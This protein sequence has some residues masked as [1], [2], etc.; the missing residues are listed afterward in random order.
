M[1]PLQSAY[2]SGHSTETALTRVTN[3]ILSSLDSRKSVFLV[4]LDLLAAFDIVDH[5]ILLNR[6][7]ARIGLGGT[8]L[9]WVKSYLKGQT[10]YVS[11]SDAKS[12]L[13]SL[14]YGVLQGS[15]LGPMFFMV[16]TLPIGDIVC[17]HNMSF[18]LYADNTQLYLSFNN[19][20]PISALD[21]RTIMESCITDIQS[22]MQL[23]CLKLNGIRTEF[24]HFKPD[25]KCFCWC[26]YD[27]A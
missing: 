27:H 18:H 25:K 21:T 12:S 26:R 13:Q 6:L 2:W 9:W 1:E 15:V 19:N 24:L 14:D 5:C 22:W 17:K 23:K 11:I 20:D 4:L 8:P 16:Y 10:Q 3:D 7:A